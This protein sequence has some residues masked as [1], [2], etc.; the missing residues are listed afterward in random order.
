M[1]KDILQNL[2]KNFL[3]VANTISSSKNIY[4]YI[5]SEL[6]DI[7]NSRF[8]YLSTNIIPKERLKR[9][10]EIKK[11]KEDREIIVSTQLIEAGVDIDVDTV[12]RDF[13]PLDSINQIAGRC[14][15]E[16]K[17]IKGEVRIVTLTEKEG[18]KKYC[19][20][21]YENFILEKTKQVFEE[22]G[23]Q[24]PIK[25]LKL[26]ELNNS[27]FGKV[28]EGMS[29]DESKK[30]LNDVKELKFENLLEFKLIEKEPYKVDVFV[31]LDENAIRL[32]K[33]YESLGEIKDSIKRRNEWLRIKN[34]FYNYIISVDAKKLRINKEGAL[35]TP[36]I[37]L[38]KGNY[39]LETGFKEMDN[40]TMII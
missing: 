28:N 2:D 1:K 7:T 36:I 33:Q 22:M 14:N 26:L 23:L 3:I 12:Y 35:D 34:E 24:D 10:K 6:M 18:G 4:N 39:D 30:V 13:A 5:K 8:Y 27:Y 38:P 31:E 16:F 9:I 25:E 17:D 15:R 20:Y 19:G 37:F 32:R 11:N 29:N 21:I 40:G